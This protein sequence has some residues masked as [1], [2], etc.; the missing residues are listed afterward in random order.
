MAIFFLFA[1]L[2]GAALQLTNAY[3]DTFLHDFEN[4]P[5]YQEFNCGKIPGDHYEYFASFG[6]AVYPCYS[7]FPEKIWY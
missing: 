6:N 3:G 5:E 4:I 7:F 1:M 2:L